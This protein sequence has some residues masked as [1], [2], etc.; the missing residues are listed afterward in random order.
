[1]QNVTVCYN[2][3]T[4]NQTNI[5][6]SIG[7][8]LEGP[9]ALV[10]G[11]FGILVNFFAVFVI[12]RSDLK[13][14]FFYWLL[15]CLQVFDSSFLGCSILESFRRHIG[16]FSIHNVLFANFLFPFKSVLMLCSIFTAIALSIERYNALV[17]PVSHRRHGAKNAVDG[18]FR[19]HRNRLLKYMGP[20]ILS[21]IC[22]YI[23]GFT[24]YTS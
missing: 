6:E 23:T 24:T 4:V 11:T 21:C 1:M 10:I 15:I 22:F 16:T 2:N 17:N 7:W 8:V 13:A 3:L 12:L 19:N 14:S 5:L 20:I 9:G 18:S